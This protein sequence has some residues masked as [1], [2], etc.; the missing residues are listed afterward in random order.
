[1]TVD[2]AAQSS[3][4]F[5]L[6]VTVETPDGTFITD[7]TIEVRSTEFNE[8]ALGLTFG[9][10]AFLILFYITRAIRGRRSRVE[11]AG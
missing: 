5:P 6:V 7:K 3:G 4:I 2:V 1:L 10:L 8:I 11:P 9:A